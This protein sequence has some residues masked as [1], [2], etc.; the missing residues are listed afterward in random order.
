MSRRGGGGGRRELRAGS[1]GEAVRESFGEETAEKLGTRGA[2]TEGPRLEGPRLERPRLEG[3][4]GQGEEEGVDLR[5]FGRLLD[6]GWWRR[7]DVHRPGR[8]QHICRR[9]FTRDFDLPHPAG[10]DCRLHPAALV[11]DVHP[12]APILLLHA[13]QHRKRHVIVRRERLRPRS[14]RPL[15]HTRQIRAIAILR[16]RR[17]AGGLPGLIHLPQAR[18][19]VRPGFPL[20]GRRFTGRAGEPGLGEAGNGDRRLGRIEGAG[21]FRRLGGDWGW[22]GEDLPPGVGGGTGLDLRWWLER[23]NGLGR[24]GTSG[25]RRRR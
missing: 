20:R 24:V 12:T 22:V 16:G 13:H 5:R 25:R 3:E 17:A 21:V 6:R 9:G 11:L 15:G 14:L 2:R 1:R 4:T 19:E 10:R 23:G 7:V 18:E 8:R